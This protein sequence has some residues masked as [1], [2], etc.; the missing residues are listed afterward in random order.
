MIIPNKPQMCFASPS[1]FLGAQGEE[2]FFFPY[3]GANMRA[4]SNSKETMSGAINK[5]EELSV[6]TCLDVLQILILIFQCFRR[7]GFCS[8]RAQRT[9]LY[10]GVFI[11]VVY[12][13]V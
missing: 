6:H 13:S 12:H 5:R 9:H 11:L 8:P 4:Q 10:G 3:L 7:M 2:L 1:V